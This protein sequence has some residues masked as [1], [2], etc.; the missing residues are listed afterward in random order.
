MRVIVA[1]I[2][3]SLLIGCG[4]RSAR[5]EATPAPPENEETHTVSLS[6]PEYG[7]FIHNW[8]DY[9][10][11]ADH[12]NV[13]G[14]NNVPT[15]FMI[16]SGS[17]LI[18]VVTVERDARFRPADADKTAPFILKRRDKM[19]N[20]NLDLVFE[21]YG[22]PSLKVTFNNVLPAYEKLLID[23]LSHET[24]PADTR[25]QELFA[26]HLPLFLPGDQQSVEILIGIQAKNTA[27]ADTTSAFEL[28]L[29]NTRSAIGGV[30][31]I[32]MNVK[33]RLRTS[34]NHGRRT[35]AIG[36]MLTIWNTDRSKQ[37]TLLRTQ[38]MLML[39][40]VKKNKVVWRTPV[41]KQYEWSFVCSER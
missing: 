11:F 18:G 41:P 27:A 1:A 9:L 14:D 4:P 25:V 31:E 19:F 13:C 23:N 38:E 29:R 7:I 22:D 15:A 30:C 34:L 39:R 32:D 12:G 10:S 3:I 28:M 37:W 40:D 26:E 35:V 2:S 16:T 8:P 17:A 33:G 36:D 21:P 6:F 24:P 5:E 20:D